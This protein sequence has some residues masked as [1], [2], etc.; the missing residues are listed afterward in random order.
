M[1]AGIRIYWKAMINRS[2]EMGHQD[3]RPETF[4]EVQGITQNEQAGTLNTEIE[5]LNQK[6]NDFKAEIIETLRKDMEKC[7]EKIIIHLKEN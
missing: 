3:D 5:R 4:I 2:R 6:M 1:V 7:E